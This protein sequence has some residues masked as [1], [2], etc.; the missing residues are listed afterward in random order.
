MASTVMGEVRGQRTQFRPP[1]RTYG[2][3]G[4]AYRSASP[5]RTT[6]LDAVRPKVPRSIIDVNW[7]FPA[8]GMFVMTSQDHSKVGRCRGGFARAE[9]GWRETVLR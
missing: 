5:A 3:F 7:A 6:V 4:L 8:G 1:V 9:V 2:G